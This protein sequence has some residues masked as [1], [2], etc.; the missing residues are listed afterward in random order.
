MTF[1][2][3]R[4]VHLLLAPSSFHWISF[5]FVALPLPGSINLL[6]KMFERQREALERAQ[7]AERLTFATK[8]IQR[9]H[10]TFSVR[11]E[12]QGKR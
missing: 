5:A 10:R 11:K 7:A 2:K 9:K 8:L 3:R 4:A 1:G 12:E 6:D